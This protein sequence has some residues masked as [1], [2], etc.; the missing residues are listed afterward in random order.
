MQLLT[1]NKFAYFN[2]HILDK[3]HAG[4]I[5]TGPEVK[6]AKYGNL[7][8]K[9]SYCSFDS[10]NE[11]WIKDMH[12]APYL[13]AKREQR[14]YDPTRSRK[15]LL[16][17]KELQSL[18]GKLQQ[19]GFSLVPLQIYVKNKFI[20]LEIGLGRGKKKIDKREVIK[21]RE[22]EREIRRKFRN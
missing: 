16:N 22:Q 17:K 6:S 7:N 5:L 15:L 21:K 9:N 8:L 18:I 11:L 10:N 12:I 19:K 3:W 20:K 13:P 2:Y 14:D 4:I 1:K